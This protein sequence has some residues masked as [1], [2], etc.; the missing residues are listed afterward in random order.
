[1]EITKAEG[2]ST[3]DSLRHVIKKV[4]KKILFS[5]TNYVL[6]LAANYGFVQFI[7]RRQQ[8]L[9]DERGAEID[10]LQNELEMRHKVEKEQQKRELETR[11]QAEKEQQRQWLLDEQRAE[12]QRLL[13]KG[14]LL[15]MDA[16][17]TI[18]C[19]VYQSTDYAKCFYESLQQHTPELQTGEARLMIIANDATEE[20][21]AFLR[22]N[23]YPFIEHRNPKCNI[24]DLNQRGYAGPDYIARV[25][26]G[27]NCGIQN[28]DT[29]EIVLMNSDN[30]VSSG[31]L[32]N[33]RKRLDKNHVVSPVLV[34]PHGVFPN[35]INGTHSLVMDFGCGLE[36]FKKNEARF[37]AWA[38]TIKQ[39]SVGIGNP[40]MPL[41]LYKWQAELAGG[42]PEGNIA[43][44][45]DKIK[46]SGDTYFFRKLDLLGITHINSNDSVIY[47]LQEG[48]KYNK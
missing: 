10:R 36:S 29:P 32:K 3:I 12:L 40:F 24:E 11:F 23:N 46:F 31:W 42:F 28:A 25:Y 16:K 2:Y 35:P 47:H 19:L 30:F 5:P 1:M 38:E 21:L 44:I 37:V 4:I 41:L 17:V 48:E 22:E 33:L 13:R 9:I 34:Q 6:N 8:W 45:D 39:N 20:M 43:D 15:K 7:I 18:I 14:L 27:Y 26:N